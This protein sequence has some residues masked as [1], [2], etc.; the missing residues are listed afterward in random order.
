[1]GKVEPAAYKHVREA[2]D[3]WLELWQLRMGLPHW[4][5]DLIFLDTYFADDEEY[6]DLK[7][8]ATT[9]GRWNYFMA[10]IKVYLPHA[11]T[12]SDEKL[13]KTMVH[14]LCHVLLMAEQSVVKKDEDMKK[15][16]MSTEHVTRALWR[17]WN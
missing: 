11:V 3:D 14:E 4:E 17:A 2:M 9:E 7:V 1:M 8:T 16:E 13:E 6:D 10:N 5:I 15:V 12:L